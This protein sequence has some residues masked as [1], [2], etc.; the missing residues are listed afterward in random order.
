VKDIQRREEMKTSKQTNDLCNEKVDIKI[1]LSTLWVTIMFLFVFA[2]LKAIYQTGMVD[3][4]RAGEI[5]G[6]KI[7]QLFLFSTA[8]L[9]SIPAIMVFLS[10]VLRPKINRVV[11]ISVAALFIIINIMTYFICLLYNPGI[12]YLRDNNKVCYKM[13]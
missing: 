11:N 10:L 1:I 6:L 5:I 9:M 12:Y 13:A 4:L 3:A 2:D 8:I 7:N